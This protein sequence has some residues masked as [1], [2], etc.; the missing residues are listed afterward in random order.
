VDDSNF[1]IYV[2]LVRQDGTKSWDVD[3]L[4]FSSILPAVV[5]ANQFSILELFDWERREFAVSDEE[6]KDLKLHK[7]HR[8]QLKMK[9]NGRQLQ[10]SKRHKMLWKSLRMVPLSRQRKLSTLFPKGLTGLKDPSR[11]PI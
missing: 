3:T 5:K 1:A 6:T 4:P 10:P 2:H 9:Y 7:K 8:K 11:Y